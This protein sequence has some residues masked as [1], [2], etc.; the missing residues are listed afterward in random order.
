MRKRERKER[1]PLIFLLVR[2]LRFD[3]REDDALKVKI[4]FYAPLFC[5]IYFSKIT[6]PVYKKAINKLSNSI[7]CENR[8]FSRLCSINPCTG[9][10]H[11]P[12]LYFT[13]WWTVKSFCIK[14]SFFI[15]FKSRFF[16]RPTGPFYILQPSKKSQKAIV[17]KNRK[18]VH[19][20]N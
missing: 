2:Y 17:K 8:S 9:L 18:L 13:R 4:Q 6:D 19:K 12:L 15:F 7:E 10:Y 16:I 11:T 20:E 3:Q 14:F 1:E 5:N